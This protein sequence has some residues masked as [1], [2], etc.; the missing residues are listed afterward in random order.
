MSKPFYIDWNAKDAL[1][2]MNQLSDLEELAYRRI[3]DMIYVTDDYLL[4][5]DDVLAWLTKT[6]KKWKSIKKRLLLL[7]KIEVVDNRI[8][9]KKCREKLAES[10]SRIEQNRNAGK[11]SAEKRKQL[12]LLNTTST[13][14]ATDDETDVITVEPTGEATNNQLP[15]TK[16]INTPTSLPSSRASENGMGVFKKSERGGNSRPFDVTLLLSDSG[17]AEA[18]KSAPGWDIYH[19]ASIY[20]E[21]VG[22]RGIPNN[23]DKAFPAW[24]LIYTKGNPP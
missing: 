17:F 4:D 13:D 10:K 14:V 8:T 22:K 21:G 15:N 1:D 18:R 11:A 24:C 20:N 19:L 6:G 5:D 3:I 9:N 2:G 16:E 12:N 7:G 23:P